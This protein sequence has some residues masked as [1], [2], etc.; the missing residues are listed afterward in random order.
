MSEQSRV[1]RRLAER[2]LTLPPPPPPVG[3]FVGA[4]ASG[5]VLYLSGAGP[6]RDGRATIVGRV[7]DDV[8]IEQA[9]AAAELVALNLLANAKSVLGDLDRVTRVLKLLCLV[10]S[11]AGFDRQPEVANGASELLIDIFGERG[12]HARSAI[13][14]SELPAGIPVEIEAIL[15]FE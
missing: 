11:A 4:V 14:V 1:E 15:E 9:R 5:N 3:R 8:T 13:G 12:Q 2:G 6:D 7:G 10:R